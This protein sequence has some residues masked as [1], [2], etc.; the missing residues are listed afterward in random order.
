MTVSASP[1][2]A[3]VAGAP[4]RLLTWVLIGNVSI[5]LLAMTACLS[6]MAGW[7]AEFGAGRA[8]VQAT[9]GTFLIT[10]ALGQL[11]MGPISDRAG[12]RPVLLGGLALFVA[13]SL[14]LAFAGSIETLILGRAVQ[15][16]GACATIVAARALVQDVFEGPER[17]RVLAF[18]GIAMGVTGPSGAVAGGYVQAAFGWPAT[19]LLVAALGAVLLAATALAVPPSGRAPGARLSFDGIFS[20]YARL[21]RLPEFMAYVLL[22]AGCTA[23]FYAFVGGVPTVLVD[24]GVPAKDIGWFL[25]FCSGAFILGN[26][27]TSRLA[28]SLGDLRLMVLGNVA[29]VAGGLAVLAVA[30]GG[31]TAALVFVA[32]V[33]LMGLG[34]GLIQPPA[35]KGA[36]SISAGDAGAGAA[37]SGAVMQGGGALAGYALGLVP[38]LDQTS[39]ALTMLV[40]TLIAA[41]AL[42]PLLWRRAAAAG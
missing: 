9:Y 38:V 7:G 28:R 23:A 33:L 22:A 15:G 31:N 3:P 21:L 11:V 8:A 30:L 26:W 18:T 16:A 13:A 25:F 24:L 2:K 19:F 42:L 34:H 35:I 32:P 14:G 20:G 29:T 10:F 4:P 17:T 36:T 1:P 12:R 27:L 39:M 37:F 5:G 41:V 6:A 40:P